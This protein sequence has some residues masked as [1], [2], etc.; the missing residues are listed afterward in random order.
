MI[1]SRQSNEPK[2]VSFDFQRKKRETERQRENFSVPLSDIFVVG[3]GG[4]SVS[5][6]DPQRIV[7]AFVDLVGRHE[8]AFYSFVHQVHSKGAGLFDG[9]MNWIERIVNFVRQGL[10]QRVSL[11]TLLPHPDTPERLALISEI[12]S[13]I[14][15]HRKLKV[16]HHERMTKRLARLDERQEDQVADA[17]FVQG[18]MQNLNLDSVVGGDVAEANREDDTDSEEDALSELEE[19]ADNQARRKSKGKLKDRVAIEPPELVLIPNLV[20]LFTVL[21]QDLLV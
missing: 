16:A 10:P 7:Q 12:D 19:G 1:S 17:A 20:P 2:S 8:G 13:V 21:V 5:F 14:E 15:Y 9:L 18:V 4:I 3:A 6:G 11:E